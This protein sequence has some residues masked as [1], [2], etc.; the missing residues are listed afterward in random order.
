[1][2]IYHKSEWDEVLKTLN[3]LFRLI[4]LNAKFAYNI[5]AVIFTKNE[6]RLYF[7]ILITFT[8]I[9]NESNNIY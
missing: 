2:H 7:V 8:I 1:M 6:W 3:F 5:S 4:F 9:I